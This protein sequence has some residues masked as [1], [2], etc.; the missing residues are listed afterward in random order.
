MAPNPWYQRVDGA[1]MLIGLASIILGV[2]LPIPLHYPVLVGLSC[3]GSSMAFVLIPACKDL[4]LKANLSG[5]DLNKPEAI[6][7]RM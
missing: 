3:M 5:M 7:K 1:L 6:R 2:L 4:F